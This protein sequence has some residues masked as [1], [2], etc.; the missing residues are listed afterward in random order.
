MF[1]CYTDVI[2][3]GGPEVQI[4]QTN[5]LL[6]NKLN[7]NEKGKTNHKKQ[8]YIKKKSINS[9]DQKKKQNINKNFLNT[10]VNL[11]NKHNKKEEKAGTFADD[12][13]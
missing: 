11:K 9:R 2:K 3:Y 12:N 4:S 7:D 13:I 8:N 5:H 1:F 10:K 6:K